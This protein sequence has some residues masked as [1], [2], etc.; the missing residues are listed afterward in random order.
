MKRDKR[1]I[2]R[3]SEDDVELLQ[4]L[5]TRF[6]LSQSEVIR[7]ALIV[8]AAKVKHNITICYREPIKSLKDG[9]TEINIGEPTDE[10][11]NNMINSAFTKTT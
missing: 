9:T 8:F 1:K 10:D 11:W 7:R 5:S 2:L 6:S 4:S 3:M